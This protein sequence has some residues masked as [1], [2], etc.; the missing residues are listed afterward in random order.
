IGAANSEFESVLPP[1]FY[2]AYLANALD[3]QRRFGESQLLVAEFGG[4]IV[5]AITLYPNAADE[6]W[7]WPRHWTGIRALAVE[8]SA[9]GL[10]IGLRLADACIERSRV[11]GAPTVCLHTAP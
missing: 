4:R 5:G 1:A 8:P 7:G 3:V 10:G 11:L 2:G 9:R 6:G